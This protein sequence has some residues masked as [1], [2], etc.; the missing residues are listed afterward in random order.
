[1]RFFDWL[2]AKTLGRRK[3]VVG[4]KKAYVNF[5]S[6]APVGR[7]GWDPKGGMELN[8]GFAQNPHLMLAARPS[9][10]PLLD[11]IDTYSAI[12]A[13]GHILSEMEKLA[14]LLDQWAASNALQKQTAPE[15]DRHLH[16]T[17]MVEYTAIAHRLREIAKG[18]K[19]DDG[20]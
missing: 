19:V 7:W 1:V 15:S 6:G 9:M 5:A 13:L 17:L 3:E 12:T 11:S 20:R 2:I 10:K 16:H 18:E 8:P 4:G 14:K